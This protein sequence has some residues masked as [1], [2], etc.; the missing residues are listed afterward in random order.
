MKCR[1]QEPVLFCCLVAFSAIVLLEIPG[2]RVMAGMGM[3][4]ELSSLGH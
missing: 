2:E 1:K 4:S 3:E